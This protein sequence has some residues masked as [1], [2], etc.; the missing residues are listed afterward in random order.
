[1]NYQSKNGKIVTVNSCG[2]LSVDPSMLWLAASPDGIVYDPMEKHH[3]RGCLEVKFPFSCEKVLFDVT[4][5]EVQNFCLVSNKSTM[6]LSRSHAYYYQVQTQMC[7]TQLHWCDFVIWSLIQTVF[8]ECIVYDLVFMK[9][10][11]HK[12]QA[13]N[14]DTLLPSILP[15]ILITNGNRA[16]FKAQL[17]V[18]AV[19]TIPTASFVKAALLVSITKT[20][21]P[22]SNTAL[23]V[24]ITK[25][26][27]ATKT[28]LPVSIS[29]TISPVSATKTALPVSITKSV[30]TTP[31]VLISKTIPPVSATKTAPLV[32]LT[33]V[34]PSV[35]VTKAVQPLSI[36]KTISIAKAVPP[37]FVS[38]VS[39]HKPSIKTDALEI[40]S[41][42]KH[43]SLPLRTVLHCL[44][45]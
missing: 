28:T 11:L 34:T 5:K 17:L 38:P 25:S 29:K 42:T 20:I 39:T 41:A 2:L 44:E 31:P 40:T 45:I 37:V 22:V 9:A 24:S 10:A 32:S 16:T 7:V 4:Y 36:A 6:S 3:K 13:F 21:P 23:P 33:K 14:F 15:C 12:T 8:V 30:K 27:S 19:Q 43:T 18:S 26:V 35:S 1:M